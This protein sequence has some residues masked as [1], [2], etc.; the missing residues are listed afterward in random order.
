MKLNKFSASLLGIG[1]IGFMLMSW[2]FASTYLINRETLQSFVRGLGFLGPIMFFLI[3]I[4]YIV[5]VP[6]YNTPIHLMAGYLFG[7]WWGFVINYVATSLGLLI[8]VWLSHRY[9]RS[10]LQRLLNK[11]TMS[12]FDKF[13]GKKEIT[14]YLLF[15]IY[16][17]PLF[18]DD[19][20][21]Y[22]VALSRVP[23]LAYI[24]AILLGNI[25][26]ASVSFIGNNP[27]AGIFPA[28]MIRVVLLLFGT[29]YFFRKNIIDLFKI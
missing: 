24:P 20:I 3:E 22:L 17:L 15:V 28:V 8:I 7:P 26:K 13:F 4:A 2:Y 18:P 6:I 21:T 29:A 14:P 23:F 9:G 1:F 25:A 10:L 12:R 5:L 11:K 16:V 27:I 19:E